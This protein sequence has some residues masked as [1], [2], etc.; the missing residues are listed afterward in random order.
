MQDPNRN[1]QDGALERLVGI[2]HEEDIDNQ[3][4]NEDLEPP[5]HIVL[6]NDLRNDIDNIEAIAQLEQNDIINQRE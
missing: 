6:I 5:N 1:L 2:G 4:L 3:I